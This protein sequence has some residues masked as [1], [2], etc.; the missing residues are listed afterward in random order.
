LRLDV[1]GFDALTKDYVGSRH[2]G[3][4]GRIVDADNTRICNVFVA[5]QDAL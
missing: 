2:L 3:C 5:Y 4:V 1:A